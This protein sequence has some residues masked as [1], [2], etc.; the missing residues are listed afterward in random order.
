MA[1]QAPKQLPM[2]RQIDLPIVI[3]SMTG[4][5]CVYSLTTTS[6]AEC[7]HDPPVYVGGIWGWP[8]IEST[9]S[10]GKFRYDPKTNIGEN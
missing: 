7:H 3:P 6:D 4:C 5:Y 9:D 10:C 2:Q 8:L 1:K